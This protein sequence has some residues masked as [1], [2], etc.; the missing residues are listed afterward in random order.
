MKLG[1]LVLV[2]VISSGA[3]AAELKQDR[4]Q[5]SDHGQPRLFEIATD[6]LHVVTRT[7]ARRVEQFAP[8][9]SAEAVRQH[10][11]ARRRATGDV[12]SSILPPWIA[13]TVTGEKR[14]SVSTRKSTPSF[15]SARR[16]AMFA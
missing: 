14:S 13:S 5:L 15:L 8:L 2:V 12:P 9:A 11:D 1:L 4:Y 3:A 7:G 6:E 16:T 10:A